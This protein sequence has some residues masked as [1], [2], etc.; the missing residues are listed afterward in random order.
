MSNVFDGL[1]GQI[2]ILWTRSTA[3]HCRRHGF[4]ALHEFDNLLLQLPESAVLISFRLNHL[5]KS[6]GNLELDF[7]LGTIV[8]HDDGVSEV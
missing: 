5:S 1:I 8:L 2:E 3:V 6:L 4:V 7:V